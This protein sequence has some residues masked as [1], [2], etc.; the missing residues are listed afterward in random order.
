MSDAIRRSDSFWL[1]E[2][3]AKKRVLLELTTDNLS[4]RQL[5]GSKPINH[6]LDF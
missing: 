5:E 2:T 1:S 3:K 4:I 6:D